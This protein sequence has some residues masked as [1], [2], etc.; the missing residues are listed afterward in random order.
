MD[1]TVE[2][3]LVKYKREN[4]SMAEYYTTWMD[5]GWFVFTVNQDDF[6]KSRKV[7]FVDEPK[8]TTRG[9]GGIARSDTNRL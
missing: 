4:V 5:H 1:R 2:I 6:S 3:C 8:R 9:E 7:E